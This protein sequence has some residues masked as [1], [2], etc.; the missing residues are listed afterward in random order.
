M[1]T[2]MELLQA[3][4]DIYFIYLLKFCSRA[5]GTLNLMPGPPFINMV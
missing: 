3:H 1:W 4:G 5:T 2:P